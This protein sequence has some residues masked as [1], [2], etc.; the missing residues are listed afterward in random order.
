MSSKK[1][2]LIFLKKIIW[3][4]LSLITFSKKLFLL[5]YMI[6]KKTYAC[7]IEHQLSIKI[8]ISNHDKR[9]NT[10]ELGRHV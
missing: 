3:N 1:F 2:N 8:F 6:I 4:L 10:N 5:N 7:K 9:T